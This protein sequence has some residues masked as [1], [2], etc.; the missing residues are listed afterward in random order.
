MTATPQQAF[1]RTET[2]RFRHCDPAGIVFYPRYVEMIND[3]VEAWFDQGLG[4]SFHHLHTE[5]KL[6]TPTAA[7]E[8]A[9]LTPSRWEDA[10]TQTLV[11][12]RIGG[13]SVALSIAFNGPDG[14]PRIK[15]SLTLVIVD[16][17]TFRSTRI[18]DDLRRAMDRYLLS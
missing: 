7:L 9:F 6:G 18:P 13:A 11:V 15:A 14:A 12:E 5:R 17:N 1:V 3:F 2:V 10:L 8:V 4:A 16:L